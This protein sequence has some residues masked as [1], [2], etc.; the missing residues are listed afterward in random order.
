MGRY[1]PACLPARWARLAA[2]LLPSRPCPPLPCAHPQT[3]PL[4]N[5]PHTRSPAELP[6]H[7]NGALT[8]TAWP[9]PLQAFTSPCSTPVRYATAG[10]L[11]ALGAPALARQTGYCQHLL[12][13]FLA[14]AGPGACTHHLP[15]AKALIPGASGICPPRP[16]APCP[17][18]HVQTSAPVFDCSVRLY[19]TRYNR[20]WWV[21]GR[22]LWPGS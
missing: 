11:L 8:C 13:H 19:T 20:P 18:P 10:T 1:P 3:S 7:C 9:P 5:P 17:S 12:D 2:Q 16:V 14:N 22:C 4:H 21:R 15:G 6:L